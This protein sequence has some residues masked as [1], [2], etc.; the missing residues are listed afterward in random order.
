MDY[1]ELRKFLLDDY[2]DS[3]K[4]EWP[5]FREIS[6][7]SLHNALNQYDKYYHISKFLRKFSYIYMNLRSSQQQLALEHGL[8]RYNYLIS[9]LSAYNYIML[10]ITPSLKSFNLKGVQLPL[11]DIYADLIKGLLNFDRKRTF[12]SLEKLRS[13]LIQANPKLIF[14]NND[15]FPIGRAITIVS[16]ELGIKTVEIQHG[17]FSKDDNIKSGKYVDYVFVWGD[18]FKNA[19]LQQKIK[20]NEQLKVLGY[21]HEIKS[22]QKPWNGTVIYL[23]QNFEVFDHRLLK[24]K[25]LNI[26]KLSLICNKLG[27][28]FFYKPHPGD[29][30]EK[31]I[32][33]IP[34]MKYLPKNQSLYESFKIGDIFIS[35]NSTS[36]V[37]AALH[38]KICIQLKNYDLKSDDFADLGVCPSFKNFFDLELYLRDITKNK[39]SKHSFNSVNENYIKIPQPKLSE[40]FLEL[41]NQLI[42]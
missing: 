22:I 20:R 42:D 24:I 25:L 40:K 21:P 28:R 17:I 16:K 18:Y 6:T 2:F 35:F 30:I 9:E 23:G 14:I 37:E 31:L 29:N 4:E 33:E 5:I 34:N 10:G 13:T 11:F 19:Y 32:E 1:D 8:N 36:L 38:S 7:N 41:V 15:M 12:E 26:K 3:Y 27:F 39:T